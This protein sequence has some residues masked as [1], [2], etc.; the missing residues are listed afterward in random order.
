[1]LVSRREEE[2]EEK[3]EVVAGLFVLL[4]ILGAACGPC[5]KLKWGA[6]LVRVGCG[7]VR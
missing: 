6:V 2:E 3:E 4:K 5:V 1:M 7:E